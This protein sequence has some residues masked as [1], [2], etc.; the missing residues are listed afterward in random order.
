M[1]G[2]ETGLLIAAISISAATAA[3]SAAM[4][5]QQ[6]KQAN[7]MAHHNAKLA[8]QQQSTRQT[9]LTKK[10]D[11]AI[12]T[13]MRARDV[14]ALKER[15]NLAK[16]MGKVKVAQASGGLSTGGGTGMKML[17]S[18]QSTAAG[19]ADLLSMNTQEQFKN[20]NSQ[21]EAGNIQSYQTFE[22]QLM[23]AHAMKQNSFLS[24]LSGGIQ[25]LGTGI[26]MSSGI[27]QMNG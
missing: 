12:K 8:R 25:G 3:S 26:Q 1:T 4:A 18:V 19:N 13:T 6:A 11:S 9:M 16:A 14:T 24:G 21:F 23:N 27:N 22:Q 17:A 20:I 15:R 2:I 5:M 10:R 7:M